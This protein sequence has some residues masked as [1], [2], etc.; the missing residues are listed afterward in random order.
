MTFK[1]SITH[2]N[3]A[4][5]ASNFALHTVSDP[6]NFITYSDATYEYYCETPPGPS[7]ARSSAIWRVA[8]KTIATG[9]VI[10]AGTGKPEHA[11][12]N[13]ATVAA[14]TYTLGA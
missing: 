3:S 4:L 1:D 13:I 2:Q 8:R 14:L 11:A 5:N 10:Y 7:V 6:L 12:T 9:D